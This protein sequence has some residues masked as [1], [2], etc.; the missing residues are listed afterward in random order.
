M[1][2]NIKTIKGYKLNGTDEDVGSFKEFFFD[3]KFWTIR[4]LVATTG[5]LFNRRQVLISPYF[6]SNIDHNAELINVNLTK[7]EIE[8]SPKYDSDKPVSRQYEEDYYNYYGAPAYWGGPSMW[9]AN[10]SILRDRN[11]WKSVQ[12]HEKSWDSNLRSS[13]DVTGHDIQA[14][15]GEIGHVDDFIFDDEDYAIRYL[16]IDTKDWLP[17]K[18]VLISPEWIDKIS[19]DDKKV[20]VNLSRNAIEN[21]PEYDEDEVLGRDDETRLYQHYNKHGYW[22]GQKVTS[23]YNSTSGDYSR[24]VNI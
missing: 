6:L 23:G 7:D 14:T 15:D 20:I 11:S 17:G 5:G 18:K 19:W 22:S 24:S 13:K 16:V 9:G 8:N 1:L 4:Y 10:T 12:H 21:A 3:D 2:T